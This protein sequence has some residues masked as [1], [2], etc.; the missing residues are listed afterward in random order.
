MPNG[1]IV[2][3]DVD[4]ELAVGYDA[5]WEATAQIHAGIE[6]SVTIEMGRRWDRVNGWH[7][8]FQS[9]EADFQLSGPSW[10][11]DGN[12][13]LR[14]F[15][16][17]KVTVTLNS[18]VGV[19][20]H[21]E[22]YLNLTGQFQ[23]NPL[24]CSAELNAGVDSTVALNLAVWDPSLGELPEATF[25][26]V[27]PTKL[28]ET[29]CQQVIITVAA[30]PEFG[31]TVMGGGTYSS[32]SLVTVSATAAA[33]HRFEYWTESGEIVASSPQYS[34]TATTNR[35]LVAIFECIAPPPAQ[36]VFNGLQS[37][38]L[39]PV[40]SRGD[41]GIVNIRPGVSINNR[42][43]VAFSAIASGNRIRFSPALPAAC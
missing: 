21:V 43:T 22:P 7:G 40:A 36:D 29:N 38:D 28:W 1:A 17:P 33:R 14:L 10:Q 19:S 4:F 26:L 5:N 8:V 42:G 11:V 32:N 30:T 13:A 15:C 37:A 3:V 2:W 12:A 20:A 25:E 6:S 18:L 35:A 34:F 39:R 9:E 31:G 23:A 24:A 16:R 41:L 27:P